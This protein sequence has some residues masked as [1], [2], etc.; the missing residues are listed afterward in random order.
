MAGVVVG[1]GPRAVGPGPTE[2]AYYDR[3]AYDTLFIEGREY[4]RVGSKSIFFHRPPA[5]DEACDDPFLA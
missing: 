4:H 5:P 3:C 1:V 2:I